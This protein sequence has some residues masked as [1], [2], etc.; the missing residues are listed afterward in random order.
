MPTRL[1]R[2]RFLLTGVVLF[3]VGGGIILYHISES[4]EDAALANTFS[5]YPWCSDVLTHINLTFVGVIALV[6]GIIV[7]ALGASFH[8]VLE[9]SKT[10]PAE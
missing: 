4:C 2:T 10:V 5:G 9:P 1:L 7:L 6:A 8:W 3:L